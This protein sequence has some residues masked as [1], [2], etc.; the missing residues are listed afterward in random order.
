V[1]GPAITC[2]RFASIFARMVL[3][4]CSTFDV[5]AAGSFGDTGTPR[6]GCN[7]SLRWELAQCLAAGPECVNGYEAAI[8]LATG[9]FL[10]ETAFASLEL[11]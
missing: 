1:F 3:N 11:K 9:V 7:G 2:G 8:D 6:F 10:P 5:G 4:D